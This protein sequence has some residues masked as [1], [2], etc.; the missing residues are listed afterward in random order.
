MNQ[1]ETKNKNYF[2]KDNVDNLIKESMSSWKNSLVLIRRQKIR[3][4]YGLSIVVFVI[5]LMAA[6]ILIVATNNQ[7]KSKAA[8]GSATFYW[9]ANTETDLAG[10]KIY[11]GTSPRTGTQA[12]GGYSSIVDVGKATT[13]VINNLTEGQTYYFSLVAYDTSQNVSPFSNELKKTIPVT[14]DNIPPTVS[15]TNPSNNADISGIINVTAIANDSGSITKVE[16][17]VDSSIVSTDTRSPYSFSLDSGTIGNGVHYL[18]AKAY[19]SAN[20]VGNST[21]VTI[22][23]NNTSQN[24]CTSFTY[25]DWGNCANNMQTRTITSSGPSGCTGGNPVLTQSCGLSGPICGGFTYSSWSACVNGTQTRTILRKSPI[26]C[27]G[28]NPVL[29]QS[30]NS[31]GSVTCTNFTYSDWSTCANNTQTRTVTSSSPTGCTGGNPITTQSCT[32]SAITCIS[33]TYSDWS[34]C[35]NN[36]QTRTVTSSSPSGCTGGNPL[37][38]QSCGLSGPICGGF[39]YSKWS[40]CV[41]GTQT[42]TILRRSPIGCVGGNPIISQGC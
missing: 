29:T 38:T 32:P 41:N 2:A 19:D 1:N 12:P 20:N 4:L 3:G 8:T 26:G 7:Q 21:I 23:I 35:T 36:S 10:Y 42:R 15:I 5:G 39:T 25:S 31:S 18:S 24:T 40:A 34:T 28:G 30:C 33:F 11:Y 17:Y 22:N 14:A 6:S 27:V 13:Y 9:N 37:L 16:F